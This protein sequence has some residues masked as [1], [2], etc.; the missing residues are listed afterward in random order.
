M[1]QK[2][3]KPVAQKKEAKFLFSKDDLIHNEIDKPKKDIL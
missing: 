3:N 2:C 1:S